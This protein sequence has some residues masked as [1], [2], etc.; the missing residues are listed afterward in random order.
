MVEPFTIAGLSVVLVINAIQ[1][2]LSVLKRIKRSSCVNS[3][4]AGINVEFE[5]KHGGDDG[6]D[7]D[8]DG[9]DNTR[10]PKHKSV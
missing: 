5:S 6:G 9:N 10:R 4:G 7:R 1:V 8:D 2:F 3:A